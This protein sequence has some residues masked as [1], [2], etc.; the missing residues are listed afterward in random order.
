MFGSKPKATPKPAAK[1]AA[2]KKVTK[3]AKKVAKKP[4]ANKVVKK[5][6][7]KVAAKK[8]VNKAAPKPVAAKPAQQED[9]GGDAY[10]P[11]YPSTYAGRALGAY[12]KGGGTLQHA[13]V[14]PGQP[15]RPATGHPDRCVFA[16]HCSGL[17]DCEAAERGEEGRVNPNEAKAFKREAAEREARTQKTR[18][19][20]ECAAK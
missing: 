3:A 20:A 10:R 8:A 1:K 18:L 2:P 9:D 17:P 7:K 12:D 5:V 16:N 14:S 15:Q 11:D 19:E 13:R 4:V 6:A